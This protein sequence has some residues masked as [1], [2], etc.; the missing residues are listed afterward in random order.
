MQTFLSWFAE[1][2]GDCVG[3]VSEVVSDAPPRPEEF[4]DTD[5]YL[6]N[7]HFDADHRS[8]GIGRQLVDRALADCRER[9]VRRFSLFA[10]NDGH[11]LYESVGFSEEPGWMNRY[12]E[13]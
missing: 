9:G 8:R 1:I 10:T 2:D 12:I 13:G 11:P 6:V 3:F 7:M 5:G 4:R